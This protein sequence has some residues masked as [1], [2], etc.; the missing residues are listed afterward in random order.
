MERLVNEHLNTNR[1]EFENTAKLITT[2][3]KQ[4]QKNANKAKRDCPTPNCDG[5]NHIN[6]RSASH[7]TVHNCPNR[8]DRVLEKHFQ[9][10]NVR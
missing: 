7:R 4:M 3:C 10:Q 1:S 8:S 6:K 2:A 9:E 5:K